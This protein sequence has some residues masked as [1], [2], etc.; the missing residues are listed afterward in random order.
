MSITRKA[1]RIVAGILPMAVLARL[2]LPALAAAIFLCVLTAGV[3]C[4]LFSND[5]RTNRV[6]RVLLAW[7]G[8]PDSLSTGG[9]AAPAPD[10]SHRRRNA[11][12]RLRR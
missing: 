1:S 6:S 7:R 5:A 4:W 11:A 8:N 2:G 12:S 10:P 3:A 9:P